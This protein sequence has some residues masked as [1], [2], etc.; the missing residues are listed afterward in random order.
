[1]DR[2]FSKHNS[3]YETAVYYLRLFTLKARYFQCESWIPW[4]ALE[5]LLSTS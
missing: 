5:G 3:G 2:G 4:D 1:M